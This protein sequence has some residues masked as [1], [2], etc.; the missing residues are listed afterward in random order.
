MDRDLINEIVPTEGMSRRKH[1]MWREAENIFIDEISIVKPSKGGPP[2]TVPWFGYKVVEVIELDEPVDR[3]DTHC[4]QMP[5]S[6]NAT[7][8]WHVLQDKNVRY[9]LMNEIRSEYFG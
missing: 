2:K 4:G 7:D 9:N 5:Y 8:V 1:K 6:E 3:T